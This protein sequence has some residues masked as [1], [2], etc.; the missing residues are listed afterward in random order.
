MFENFKLARFRIIITA[1]EKGLSLPRYKG[2][3]FR[4]S[5]GGVFRRIACSMRQAECGDCLLREQCPYAYIFETSPPPDT[6]ALSKYENIPRPFVIEPP[7]ET[8]TEYS[9]GERL[10]INLILI[11]RAIQYLPYFIVVFREMGE[12]GIGKG[13]RPFNLEDVTAIGL[14]ESQSIY[15]AQTNTVQN[16]DLAFSGFQL[17][18]KSPAAARRA[19]VTFETP[20]RLKDEGKIVGR[21]DFHVFFRQA[22]RRLSSLSYFHHGEALPA[23][24]TGLSERARSVSLIKNATFWHD[25]ERYSQR[26]GRRMNM[27]GLIGT[28]VYEGELDE[29]LP[30]LILCEQVHV[31]KNTVFGLGKYRMSVR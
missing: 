9:P 30:W 26:Q 16:L 27:G 1:G 12:A 17:V 6:Q 28:V 22:M 21:P 29:F 23:D 11:G 15:S 31:G 13:R 19:E 18:K 14:N 8:K 4:G 10:F 2:S 3:T 5:F 25:W 20:V 24:Y 7:L